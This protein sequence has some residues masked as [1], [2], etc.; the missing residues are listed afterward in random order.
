MQGAIWCTSLD[1]VVFRKKR[2]KLRVL[3]LSGTGSSTVSSASFLDRHG[4]TY[5]CWRSTKSS[6]RNV[7]ERPQEMREVR[8]S[9]IDGL[10]FLLIN[11]KIY[12]TTERRNDTS[13]TA[14]IKKKAVLSQRW[15]RDA[16]YIS[17][18]WA[19]A[20]IWP[21]EIFPRWRRPPYWIYSNRR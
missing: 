6:R 1:R 14:K 11:A 2:S 18:S 21:F 13:K 12:H 16:C 17:R 8:L 5:F 3:G 19:V 10:L 7:A 20:E 9:S 4:R 15:P